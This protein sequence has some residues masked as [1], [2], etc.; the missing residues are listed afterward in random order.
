MQGRTGRIR[1]SGHGTRRARPAAVRSTWVNDEI[2]HFQS[3]RRGDRIDC[4]VV[5]GDPYAVSGPTQCH[6]ACLA[7][8][9][10]HRRAS[11]G[12]S[13]RLPRAGAINSTDGITSVNAVRNKP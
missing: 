12:P 3:L 10:R 2:R 13:A 5:D 1:K 11:R 6:A 8:D 7:G 4:L 9:G